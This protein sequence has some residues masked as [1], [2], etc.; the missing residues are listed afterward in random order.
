[1]KFF[2][3]ILLL[4]AS[5]SL[6]SAQAQQKNEPF[7]IGES[8]TYEGK[9]S[10]A[11]LRGIAI[12]DLSFLV[13]EKLPDSS[14][15]SLKATAKSKGTLPKLL[16]FKF[17]QDIQSIVDGEK[18][19]VLKTVKH[20]EQ[21]D[22]VRDSEAIFD[23]KT[24]KVIYTETDPNDIARAPRRSAST[25]EN[26]TQ[27]LVTAIYMLRRMPLAVGK[28]FDLKISDSGLV[29]KIPV[30]VTARE[31]QKSV[32]GKIWCF[33][34]EPQIFGRNRLIEKEGNMI[35]WITDDALRIPVRSQINTNIGR[36]EIKLKKENSDK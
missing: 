27:D 21:G 1:M 4:F 9:F 8:L 28:S 20:D 14:N 25:I 23:Y 15:Y 2:F 6:I 26:G 29:Y 7:R 22:R 10:K 16:D 3:H 11:L 34:L 17:N 24:K 18:F 12:S 31:Q 32:L 33:R 13:V 35:L 36:V 19:Q 30:R 5:V